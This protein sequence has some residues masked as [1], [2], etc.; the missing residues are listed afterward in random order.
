MRV[1]GIDPGLQITGWSIVDG[2]PAGPGII[3]A[4]VVRISDKKPLEMRLKELHAGIK[5]VIESHQPDVMAVEALYSHYK[6]PTTAIIMGH[7]RGVIFLAA[8]EFDIPVHTYPATRIKKSLTGRGNA[9]KAQ[10]Q[11]M[12]AVTLNLDKIPE[13]PDVADAIAAALTH[14]NVASRPEGIS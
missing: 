8:G 9:S 5:E 12:V 10:V 11:Q 1:L 3:E 13:P 6:H 14:I 4:G 7:A 2:L